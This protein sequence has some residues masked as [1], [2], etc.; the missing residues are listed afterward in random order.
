MDFDAPMI[1]NPANFTVP[2]GGHYDGPV[3]TFTDIGP[4]DGP[5]GY[6]AW[7]EQQGSARRF[8]RITS[9]LGATAT[10][11]IATWIMVSA[12]LAPRACSLEFRIRTNTAPIPKRGELSRTT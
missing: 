10:S 8:P 3:T 5:D 11:F 7:T 1:V 6:T 12:I 2:A 9:R 4:D